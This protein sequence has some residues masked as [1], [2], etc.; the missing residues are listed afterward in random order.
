MKKLVIII[1][2]IS[3]I[4]VFSTCRK[5]GC[6]G[7]AGPVTVTTR[8]LASFKELVLAD[9]INLVLIQDSIEKMEI[10]GP[11]NML[12]NIRADI[13]QNILT[14]S[15]GT[16]CR[17]ARDVAEKINVRLHFKNL[18]KIDYQGS[19]TLTNIDTLKLDAL[20]IESNTG[21]GDIT[22]TLDTRYTG[23]YIF[24]E[25]ASIVLRGKSQTCFTYTNN[26][27]I[28]DMRN[29]VVNKMVIEY[30][31][32]RDTHINVRD[33]LSAVIFHKGNIYFKGNP[34]ITKLISHSSGKLIQTP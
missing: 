27:G 21:A 18:Q 3:L 17:W 11:Q 33:E 25:N 4:L 16:D 13:A 28:A 34:V 22:L 8:P 26:R 7:S 31:G 10:E 29:F 24:F 9:N 20:H 15:N 19:G 30:G 32:L 6:F 1:S 23:A 2:C 5:P 12:S 14:I